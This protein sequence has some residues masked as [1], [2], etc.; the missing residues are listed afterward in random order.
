MPLT[1]TLSHRQPVRPR[2]PTWRMQSHARGAASNQVTLMRSKCTSKSFTQRTLRSPSAD[3]LQAAHIVVGD[4]GPTLMTAQNPASDGRSAH[5]EDVG[6]TSQRRISVT[7]WTCTTQ[8][9]R[10]AHKRTRSAAVKHHLAYSTELA[11]AGPKAQLQRQ[12]LKY[13][14]RGLQPQYDL[15]PGSGQ[16]GIQQRYH[17]NPP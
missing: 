9:P 17:L 16:P 12:P 6:S 7:T 14:C 1:S 5:V 3:A 2:T 11:T 15:E 13:R 10:A 4:P 8:L